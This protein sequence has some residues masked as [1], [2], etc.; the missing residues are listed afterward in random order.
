MEWKFS[1]KSW[2]SYK[3][4]I[5]QNPGIHPSY[6]FCD[7]SSKSAILKCKVEF[8]NFSESS[9]T[10][11]F[12]DSDLETNNFLSFVTPVN[13][14]YS[15]GLVIWKGRV[16]AVWETWVGRTTVLESKDDFSGSVRKYLF[17]K[18]LLKSTDT[19]KRAFKTF[20]FWS[21]DFDHSTLSHDKA[22]FREISKLEFS[23]KICHL[24]R[25][26]TLTITRVNSM[27]LSNSH[28]I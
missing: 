21:H 19:F 22:L 28:S 8:W 17:S 23:T 10:I 1:R 9:R 3:G 16:E 24:W 14:D 2:E 7:F 11:R 13:L 15:Y 25:K 20:R 26:F 5:R 18:L 4:W 12:G 6:H 27:I